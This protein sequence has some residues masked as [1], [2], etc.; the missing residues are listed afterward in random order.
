MNSIKVRQPRI[1][2]LT[3]KNKIMNTQELK[4]NGFEFV[5]DKVPMLLMWEKYAKS[6]SEFLLASVPGF[7]SFYCIWF[8]RS[9]SKFRLGDL[10]KNHHDFETIQQAKDFAQQDF[11]S[12]ILELFEDFDFNRWKKET[13]FNDK[14][15]NNLAL[16]MYNAKPTNK[17]KTKDYDKY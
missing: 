4:D 10:K 14:V 17:N 5:K 3:I 16:E 2:L 11:E 12:K 1:T 8:E 9:I 13:R 6:T 15:P 7:D